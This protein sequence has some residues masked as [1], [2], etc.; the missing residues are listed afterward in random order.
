MDGV[1][2]G[3]PLHTFVDG[4]SPADRSPRT[5][6]PSSLEKFISRV[7][8]YRVAT[9][10][11]HTSAAE[12][13]IHLESH[14]GPESISLLHSHQDYKTAMAALHPDPVDILLALQSCHGT[15]SGSTLLA[16]LSALA[17][18]SQGSATFSTSIVELDAIMQDFLQMM[19]S[20][21]ATINVALL[22]NLIVFKGAG[23]RLQ[24]FRDTFFA[25]AAQQAVP[26]H[27]NTALLTANSI[28]SLAHNYL[29]NTGGDLADAPPSRAF[30][31]P[32]SLPP[33]S[34]TALCASPGCTTRVTT[35]TGR[36]GKPH[37]FCAEHWK[38][39]KQT[40]PP[41]GRSRSNSNASSSRSTAA[42]LTREALDADTDDASVHLAAVHDLLP[43]PPLAFL[44]EGA[45]FP[46]VASPRL[47]NLNSFSSYF[48]AL[49]LVLC[50]CTV[51]S[52]LACPFVRQSTPPALVT[53]FLQL[54]LCGLCGSPPPPVTTLLRVCT[55][56]NG[57]YRLPAVQA[58]SSRRRCRID[59]PS[60]FDPRTHRRRLYFD[61]ELL[62][63]PPP[64]PSLR[65]P[66][67]GCRSRFR[68]WVPPYPW[69]SLLPLASTLRTSAP[70]VRPVLTLLASFRLLLSAFPT[71]SGPS[72]AV[73]PPFPLAPSVPL[74]AT[75]RRRTRHR[76]ALRRPRALGF[77]LSSSP[78]PA[79]AFVAS[80]SLPAVAYWD[81]GSSVHL[82]PDLTALDDVHYLSR[83]FFIGGV[84]TGIEATAYGFHRNL[85][86]GANKCYYTP[87]GTVTL[88]SIGLLCRKGVLA[89]QQW[90]LL[91][92]SY[93]YNGQPV[94]L[95]ESPTLS[96]NLSPV[97]AAFFTVIPAPLSTPSAYHIRH[98][99]PEQRHRADQCELLHVSHG[100]PGDTALGLALD[101]GAIPSPCRS[102]DV[103][104]NRSL[105]G[106]CLQCLAGKHRRSS[107]PP[108]LTEP[109][110]T[111]GHTLVVDLHE[112]PCPSLG[113]NTH[114][115]FCVDE[116]SS[117]FDI[118]PTKSKKHAHVL[119]ALL[120]HIAVTY[121][122]RGHTVRN[123]H[124]DAESVFRSLIPSFGQHGFH[125]N[126]SPPSQHAQRVERYVQTFWNRSRAIIDSIPYSIPKALY[127]QLYCGIASSMNLLPTSTS[128]PHTPHE[129]VSGARFV[130]NPTHPF[131]PLGA[132]VLLPQDTP[133][134]RTIATATDTIL[135]HVPLTELG[136]NFGY[137]SATPGSYLFLLQN[138]EIVTRRDFSPV[139]VIPFGYKPRSVHLNSPQAEPIPPSPSV[140]PPPSLLPPDATLDQHHAAEAI[141]LPVLSSNALPL[142]SPTPP[143]QLPAAPPV[144]LVPPSTVGSILLPPPPVSSPLP[145]ASVDVAPTPA[146]VDTL[147]PPVAP[148][149]AVVDT[150][151]PPAIVVTPT[152]A[153][154]PTPVPLDVAPRRSTRVPIAPTRF[155]DSAHS[156][157][158]ALPR[159]V[160]FAPTVE[161]ISTSQRAASYSL[162]HPTPPSPPTS[163]D[164]ISSQHLCAL[165]LRQF[166]ADDAALALQPPPQPL[167]EEMSPRAARELF[168]ELAQAAIDR[169]LTKQ[170]DK[171]QSFRPIAY[172]SIDPLAVKITS[173]LF[174]KPK[175][176]SGSAVPYKM[177]A[178]LAANG[179][180]QPS[181]S[182]GSTSAET[183]DDACKMA[184]LAAYHAAAVRDNRISSLQVSDFDI[185]GAFLHESL[186][187]ENCPRQIVMLL[188]KD[189]NHPLAGTWVELRKAVYGLK[190]SNHIF[191][192]GLKSVLRTAGF[193]PT[194]A[195]PRIYVKMHPSDSSLSCAVAMHVDDGLIC[196]T[197]RPYYDELISALTSR[198]GPLSSHNE[199][200]SSNTGYSITRGADGSVTVSQEG[201][202]RRMLHDLGADSLP[203]VS[204]PSTL[205][206]FR[207]PTDSTPV[208]PSAYRKL[209]GCLIYLLKTRHDIRKEVQYLSTRSSAPTVSCVQKVY[210]VLAYL[211]STPTLGS[212]YFTTEGPTLY[213]YVDAAYGVHTDGRSQTGYYICIGKDSAPI[214]SYASAQRDCVSTGSMEAEYVGLTAACKKCLIFRALLSEL[215]FPQPGP[216][217]CFEDNKSAI[218]LANAPEIT[219]HSRHIFV[220]H[221]YIR[222]LVQQGLIVIEY[223]PTTSMTADLLTKPLA[224]G[225][226][227][228]FRSK[229]LNFSS[230]DQPVPSWS[231]LRGECQS[232]LPDSTDIP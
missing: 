165:I 214:F 66:Y 47:S 169:E 29:I 1:S 27:K 68:L 33:A 138:N 98:L 157:L 120:Q 86:V 22:K 191:D 2:L 210:R 57:A 51:L 83:P 23:P 114:M 142:L 213:I 133:K 172:P 174:L 168:P 220:R 8:S 190:Q 108:S 5:L 154:T 53:P 17:N 69:L 201:Y 162:H 231:T 164:T 21:G 109:A 48:C 28:A 171:Y 137:D 52:S 16:L 136:I 166:K 158:L 223:L 44:A 161:F 121:T 217:T 79:F 147:P 96:N 124:A 103:R 40:H 94:L 9:I 215:G 205:D 34:T 229:L 84:T 208:N 187:P 35:G 178:R 71:P 19:G 65:P 232:V 64:P 74:S 13:I 230:S 156:S 82:T 119:S 31:A 18:W 100:H 194:H 15:T 110:P 20:D 145:S 182:Y 45:V 183:T 61:L 167:G 88:F 134:R 76:R 173:R 135:K 55:V 112:L 225:L 122:A 153:V 202:L 170:L 149:P 38:T 42:M 222:D 188:P 7:E 85:P 25:T 185:E 180:R 189:I 78:I 192:N 115:I 130:Y 200:C 46:H 118:I 212:R 125:L 129:L 139:S 193:L 197:H 184:M 59:F 128:M 155:A 12:F 186:T 99:T 148:T 143:T 36:S 60:L 132:T 87:T 4:T 14:L 89:V 43:R 80:L 176:H 160:T 163:V 117:H 70:T 206:L 97:P 146:V 58:P 6:T 73:A 37:R 140:A 104:N 41:S 216:T 144:P 91:T 49:P 62:L 92:L 204:T 175:F 199:V 159:R 116:H 224:V 24:P 93:S 77:S 141:L 152:L 228:R 72:P 26:L 207:A 177:S 107:M 209:I 67:D 30:N 113:G 196:S 102:T 198:Y 123:L 101:S 226:F 50:L 221:H 90:G 95:C 227:H 211:N 181:D 131:L 81:N 3:V 56:R 151:P 11:A 105:R 203:S 111:T 195:D 126:L 179:Q 150:L 10:D 127:L 106:P 63:R 219:R 75:Q 32:S 218:N 39:Y 54:L